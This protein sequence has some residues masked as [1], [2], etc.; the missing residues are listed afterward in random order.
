MLKRH[1][2]RCSLIGRSLPRRATGPA[3]PGSWRPSVRTLASSEI[4]FLSRRS[5][6]LFLESVRGRKIKTKRHQQDLNLRSQWETD[7][8]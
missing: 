7:K 4:A 1:G 8:V 6:R 5:Q 2:P 3:V